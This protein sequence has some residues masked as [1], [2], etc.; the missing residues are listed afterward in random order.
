MKISYLC[1]NDLSRQAA[2]TIHVM[3]VAE[4]LRK[5]GHEVVLF[6]PAFG[7]YG[8]DTNVDIRYVPIKKRKFA[9]ALYTFPL[10][11]SLLRHILTSRPDC[12]YIRP[13][14]LCMVPMFLAS[15]FRIPCVLEVNGLSNDERQ[16]SGKNNLITALKNWLDEKTYPLAS[17]VIAVAEEIKKGLIEN[18][19]LSDE[20]I[21]VIG[22]G[23][24]VSLF[25]PIDS[26]EARSRLGLDPHRS[27]IGFIGNLAAWQG[28]EYIIQALPLVLEKCPKAH[29]LIVGFGPE[30]AR[31]EGLVQ[32][33]G[34]SDYVSFT[35]QVSIED[36]PWWINAFDVCVALKKPLA[37]GSPLKLFCYMA[38]G[39]PVVATRMDG[40]EILEE[41]EAGLLVDPENAH[42][43]VEACLR[44]LSDAPLREKMGRNGR[45]FVVRNRSWEKVSR[46]VSAVCE[47]LVKTIEGDIQRQEFQS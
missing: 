19:H 28:V 14:S 37:P 42:E 18:F 44:L 43:V 13:Y 36:G 8:R 20:A 47:S 31:Y 3:E 12:F 32:G 35:G 27:Y 45:D 46:R 34:L 33:L 38:C 10:V 2:A 5:L 11:I 16:I 22:N 6:A 30:W 7:R 41:A 9:G 17:K 15:F 1:C 26:Q 25:K 23:V 24:N 29:L 40:F 21:T 39:K 4:N